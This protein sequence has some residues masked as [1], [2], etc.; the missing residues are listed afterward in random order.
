MPPTARIDLV[1]RSRLAPGAELLHLDPAGVPHRVARD[2]RQLASRA[3]QRRRPV[4]LD[5]AALEP[6][7]EHEAVDPARE[8]RRQVVEHARAPRGAELGDDRPRSPR[9]GAP[10]RRCARR[11]PGPRRPSAGA[12]RR[13]SGRRGG[14]RPRRRPPRPPSARPARSRPQ[15]ARRRRRAR[16]CPTTL[17][18]RTCP[19]PSFARARL[20]SARQRSGLADGRP[21]GDGPRHGRGVE[22]ARRRLEHR[23]IAEAAEDQ[24][25]RREGG[26]LDRAHRL[27]G[28]ET[29]AEPRV[30][31][32]PPGV[33]QRA[34]RDADGAL[35]RAVEEAKRRRRGQPARARRQRGRV[36][37]VPGEGA[38][39]AVRD[40]GFASSEVSVTMPY[41]KG[42]LVSRF[43][44]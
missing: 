7:D 16:A 3:R 19:G 26:A 13:C 18:I 22:A 37:R 38:V 4:G 35:E 36:R 29:V 1:P 6:V 28:Q 39:E 27:V 42:S 34:R 8:G 33:R 9:R 2:A 5:H 20:T 40:Q 32:D 15:A 24:I 25:G 21:N 44:T 23:R 10:A 12:R 14:P 31:L 17:T 43:R 41:R 30:R 11:A